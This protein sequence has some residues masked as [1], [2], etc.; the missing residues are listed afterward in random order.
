MRGFDA[1][2]GYVTVRGSQVTAIEVRTGAR[3]GSLDGLAAFR[4]AF[5]SS[6][7]TQFVGTGGVPVEEFLSQE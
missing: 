5:G 1:G 7:T 3:T 2:V 4:S 6:A